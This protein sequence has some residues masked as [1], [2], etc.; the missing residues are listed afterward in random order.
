MC[1]SCEYSYFVTIFILRWYCKSDSTSF[2]T[3]DRRRSSSSSS[4]RSIFLSFA[5]LLLLVTFFLPSFFWCCSV[6]SVFLID[7]EVSGCDRSCWPR[8]RRRSKTTS[9][10]RVVRDSP[11]AYDASDGSPYSPS[12]VSRVALGSNFW[13]LF[14]SKF[15]EEFFQVFHDAPQSKIPKNI[16]NCHC[17]DNRWLGLYPRC[18]AGPG[19]QP[20]SK[21]KSKCTY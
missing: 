13:W 1:K 19:P 6:L 5:S 7:P 12:L 18:R 15:Y 21:W 9:N 8:S 16:P 20:R 14:N 4:F 3:I 10:G 17:G 11:P 2:A